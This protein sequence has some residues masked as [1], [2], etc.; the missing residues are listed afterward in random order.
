MTNVQQSSIFHIYLI[1]PT[2]YDDDGYPIIWK[3]TFIPSNS[4]AVLNALCL[5]FSQRQVLGSE[6]DVRITVLDESN[7][8]IVPE[9]IAKDIGQSGAR[10]FVGMVGVQT[11]QFPRALDLSFRFVDCGIPVCI[12]GFHVSGYLSTMKTLPPDAVDAQARGISFFAGEGECGRVD[13]VLS[14][15]WHGQLKP[16]YN[17]L[18]DMPDISGA[19]LPSL[20]MSEIEKSYG[21]YAPFDLG[22]GCPFSCTFCTIINVHGQKSR[23]RTA[24]ELEQIVR[25]NYANGVRQFFLTDD[26]IARNKNWRL[27]FER[28]HS[29]RKEGM[30]FRILAQVDTACH[31][32]PR[33]IPMAVAA[34]IDQILVGLE[35]MNAANLVH[36]DKKQNKIE[37]YKENL[38]AWKRY[39]VVITGSYIIGLPHDTVE[40]VWRD[41]TLIKNEL[42]VDAIYFTNITPLPGSVMHRDMVTSGEWLDGDYNR[43]DTNHYVIRHP[44]MSADEWQRANQVA[45][46]TFYTR[47]H[48]ETVIRRMV[49]CKSDKKLTTIYRLAINSS[50]GIYTTV[51]PIDGGLFRKRYRR[52]RRPGLRSAFPVTFYLW[53]AFDVL[54]ASWRFYRTVRHLLGLWKR[55]QKDPAALNYS[56]AAIEEVVPLSTQKWTPESLAS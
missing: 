53:H 37:N 31:K 55:L 16:L 44:Q 34:G 18:G 17:Y 50:L 9:R 4:L 28:L 1:K 43:Y 49:A 47:K 23:F 19:P 8:R 25:T 40:S 7:T 5:D 10:G 46:E 56:D 13:D 12:G 52:D 30:R 39:P 3:Q 14:D 2:H 29:L 35:S 51:H 32:M 33:F 45:W 15:A 24:D 42:P 22:R 38:S 36:I 48:M 21:N 26:N 20:P 54:R 6:V 27:F 41:V 11:N